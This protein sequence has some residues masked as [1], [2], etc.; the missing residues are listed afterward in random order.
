M[1]I[2]LI[3]HYAGSVR[4]G[5]EYRPYYMA[6]AWMRRGHRVTVVAASRS[7]VRQVAPEV[8]GDLSEEEI[9]GIR[10]VWLKTPPYEGNG[11]RRVANILSFVGQL[12]RHGA[13][14][15]RAARPDV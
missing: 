7:H 15:T 1:N 9:D 13:R 5:M 14:L 2:V 8:N 10:Y 11:A 12:L 6:R 3:N 4:H